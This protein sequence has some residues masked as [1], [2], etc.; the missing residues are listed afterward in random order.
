MPIRL[1]KNNARLL[2]ASSNRDQE[3]SEQGHKKAHFPRAFGIFPNPEKISEV[4]VETAS[5]M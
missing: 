1:D 3:A 5:K 2:I 4:K